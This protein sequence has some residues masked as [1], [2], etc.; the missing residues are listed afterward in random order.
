MNIDTYKLISFPVIG[1]NHKKEYAIKRNSDYIYF[2]KN[3]KDA[4]I[5]YNEIIKK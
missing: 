5:H 1:F 4:L 3:K 2:Y